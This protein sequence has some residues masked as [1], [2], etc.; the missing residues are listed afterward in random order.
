M[1]RQLIHR[2][3]LTRTRRT[4]EQTGE[5]VAESLF[6]HALLYLFVVFRLKESIQFLHL[7]LNILGEEQLLLSKLLMF[8][9]IRNLLGNSEYFQFFQ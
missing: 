1:A 5:P 7:S 2:L 6:L 4:I 3:G 8:H 9:H